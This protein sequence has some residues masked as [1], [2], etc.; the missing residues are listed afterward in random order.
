M[1]A[2]LTGLLI[3]LSLS[4]ATP[5]LAWVYKD[6]AP[7]CGTGSCDYSAFPSDCAAADKG[8]MYNDCVDRCDY[9]RAFGNIGA[10]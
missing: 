1:K 5:T 9:V 2:T 7:S 8:Y 10:M 6:S 4:T 3:A